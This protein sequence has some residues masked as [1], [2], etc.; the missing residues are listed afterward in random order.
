MH[1][2]LQSLAT[3]QSFSEF[4]TKLTSRWRQLTTPVK[5]SSSDNRGSR[6]EQLESYLHHIIGIPTVT[7]NF[8]AIED[9]LNYVHE[10]FSRH[11]MF[12]KRI[13]NNGIKSL[14]A[15]TRQTKTPKV[16]LYAHLDVVPGEPGLF[17]LRD[18][19]DRYIGR[20]AYDM[21]FSLA[22]YLQLIAEMSSEL[23]DFDFGIMVVTD[24]EIGGFMGTSHLV[25]MGYIPGVIIIPDGGDNWQ[26]ETRA[27]G[28]SH[29]TI[30][31]TG[32]SAHG[33][34]PWEGDNAID[35]LLVILTEIRERY[36]E[37]GPD[38]TTVTIGIV[39][40]GKVI[41]QVASSASAGLDFRFETPEAQ[42][43]LEADIAEICAKHGAEHTLES[44][45]IV[46][47]N[48]R[49]EPAIAS[50]ISCMEE[51]LQTP[52]KDSK[53]YG[54]SD[55]RFYM[56]K[57]PAIIVRPPGGGQHGPEEWIDKQG[58]LTFVTIIEQYLR[59]EARAQ[60]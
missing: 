32:H 21:K 12:V 15:T 7:G 22:I 60:R 57:A 25:N 48:D 56:G 23:A 41:N 37:G 43:V 27:K 16:M 58:M 18:T 55:A 30:S 46:C 38:D 14:V 47:I 36:G 1:K 13:N 42:A 35:K 44:Q 8:E 53:S 51:A 52:I 24:E 5:H 34:R 49:N 50:F 4:T 39:K 31:T 29:I 3:G 26:I 6:A 2:K 20:G 28:L 59:A 33:S 45:A 54:A 40:G 11:G 19:G 17:V 10:H 9:G